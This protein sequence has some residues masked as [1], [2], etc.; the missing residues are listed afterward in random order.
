MP[1]DKMTVVNRMINNL[2]FGYNKNGQLAKVEELKIL[3][4]CLK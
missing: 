1:C 4:N 2:M 3:K